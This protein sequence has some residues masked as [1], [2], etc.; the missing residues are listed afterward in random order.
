MT[1][2]PTHDGHIEELRRQYP[3]VSSGFFDLLEER[4][5]I[6]RELSKLRGKIASMIG[7]YE[8]RAEH[9]GNTDFAMLVGE[10]RLAIG[11]PVNDEERAP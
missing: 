6:S 10:L 7:Y 2:Q 4:D 5:R 8:R 3:G 1:D 11:L 9:A